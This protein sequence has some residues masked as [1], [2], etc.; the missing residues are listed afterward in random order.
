MYRAPLTDFTRCSLDEMS[1]IEEG[2]KW[3]SKWSICLSG[4]A[5]ACFISIHF[6]KGELT[7]ELLPQ[8]PVC[9]SV[10]YKVA[11]QSFFFFPPDAACVFIS[12]VFFNIYKPSHSCW[13]SSWF[14]SIAPMNCCGLASN[15]VIYHTGIS[16]S[17]SCFWNAR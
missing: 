14:F 4:S 11:F 8:A 16:I 13:N 3:R 6:N 12:N 15:C 2:G 10:F 17:F 9:A 1:E 7:V 5:K